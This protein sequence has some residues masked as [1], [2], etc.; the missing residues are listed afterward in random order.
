MSAEFE[1]KV[2]EFI[3]SNGLF[4]SEDKV[5]LAVSGGVDST[6]LLHAVCALKAGGV[7]GGELV[8]AHINHQLREAEADGDEDFVVGE[9][10]RLNV[11]AITR[12]V[13]V[14]EYARKNKLSIE[15]AGREL[16]IEA[17][18]D[19]AKANNCNVI[20][21]AH[22]KD[23]NA[24]T[25]LQRLTRGT[26]YRGLGGVWPK[27]TFAS[28]VTFVRPLLCVTR[29][30]I[31]EYLKQ[32]N[33]AWRVDRTN[34]DYSYRRNFI[35]HRL[36][37]ELEGR[38]SRSVVEELYELSESVRKFYG[39]VCECA[40]KVW[41]K[42]AECGDEGVILD[43]QQLSAEHPAVKV[44]LVRRALAAVGSGERDLTQERFERIL[45]LA[46]QKASGRRIE[47][48][49]GFVVR[50][51]YGKL[52]FSRGEDE[53]AT[54][55]TSDSI[56]IKVPGQT[57]FGNYLAEAGVFEVEL[58]SEGRFKAGKMS[59][60]EWFD[61]DKVKMPLVV[62]GRRAGERFIPLGSSQE[63]KVGKFLTAQRVPQRIRRRLLIA[64]DSEKIIWVWPIRISE[65]A[66]VTG[67]T[68]RILRLQITDATLE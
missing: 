48:P 31:I 34:V 60:V 1:N 68:R 16:R 67:Q 47:L 54:K 46:G 39:M 11:T 38:C 36:M 33:L 59:F 66:K 26:G 61:L 35:R 3:E 30:E 8:C 12:R 52:I 4:G 9:A 43:L 57:R 41:A 19:I 20:A 50:S 49:G 45:Q 6:A 5:L 53:Q 42:L 7:L 51:E 29:A 22:Q 63:K 13:D 32:R 2:A 58:G 23:D 44:E 14:R 27:R 21:T 37:P 24:E 17:L 10:G 15:T 18:V 65:E 56:T 40:E 28:G 55:K 64:A 25:I 62:R